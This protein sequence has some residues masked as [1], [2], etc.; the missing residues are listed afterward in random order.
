MRPL[1]PTTRPHMIYFPLSSL[2]NLSYSK[3]VADSEAGGSCPTTP[4]W[5]PGSCLFMAL[6]SSS[7]LSPPSSSRNFSSRDE[8]VLVAANSPAT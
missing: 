2:N 5:V 4:R 6:S 3:S 1:R 7:I 8:P